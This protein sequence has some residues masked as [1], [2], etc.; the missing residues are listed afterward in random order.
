[1]RYAADLLFY[2]FKAF[3]HDALAQPG[4]GRVELASSIAES[5]V[6]RNK[7][8]ESTKLKEVV[9]SKEIKYLLHFTPLPN[10]K[11]ILRFGFLPRKFLE[12]NGVKEAIRPELPDLHRY[13]GRK[14]CFCLS[15]S[16]PNYKMFYSKRRSMANEWVVIK[17][18]VESI[19]QHKCLF[20]RTNAA[21]RQARNEGPNS[22]EDMFYDGNIRSKLEIDKSFTT[23]PQ[24]EVM[25]FSRIP[26]DWI[27]EI[28]IDSSKNLTRSA[29][30]EIKS[31]IKDKLLQR[32]NDSCNI[33]IIRDNTFFG[34][35]KD[36]WF[37]KK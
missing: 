18:N 15:I 17:V 4:T 34:P 36:F 2:D 22:I 19:I 32:K 20:F 6:V 28:Y 30:R 7:S 8:G 37:W 27:E 13:D 21:S 29:D 5:L 31:L 33:K 24:A 23:D 10:L 12:M 1:M 16:W 11:N 26:P 9:F 3:L 35:R 14:E 25:S